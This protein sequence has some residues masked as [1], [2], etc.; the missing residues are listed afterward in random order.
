MTGSSRSAAVAKSSE[1]VAGRD[2]D[3][4]EGLEAPPARRRVDEGGEAGDDAGPAQ[5]AHPVGGGVG[6]QAHLRPQV[7][8][9]QAPVGSEQ[10][11]DLTV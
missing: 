8:P 7:A 9:G 2:R 3:T 6:A 1:S 4:D 10:A 5:A 11:D